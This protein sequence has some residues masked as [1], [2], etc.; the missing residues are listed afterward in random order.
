MLTLTKFDFFFFFF[1][2]ESKILRQIWRDEAT[3]ICFTGM[4]WF[5]RESEDFDSL[6]VK[7]VYFVKSM[8]RNTYMYLLVENDLTIFFLFFKNNRE[9]DS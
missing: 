4:V 5:F 6:S 7:Y 3:V 8:Y 1:L 2:N 9:F